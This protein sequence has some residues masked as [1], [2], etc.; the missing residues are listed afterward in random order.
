MAKNEDLY[1]LFIDYIREDNKWKETMNKQ[2]SSIEYQ[3]KLTNGRINK[4][5][6]VVEDLKRLNDAS[7]ISKQI[8]WKYILAGVSVLIF[9]FE[10][11][12]FFV[13]DWIKAK[14]IN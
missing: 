14:F 1:K 13:L 6:P 11:A 2:V 12:F 9:L 8:N 5:E 7:I 10:A 4:I 3:T